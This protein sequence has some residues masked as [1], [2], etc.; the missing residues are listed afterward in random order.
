MK[1]Y[2]IKKK[3]G[4]LKPPNKKQKTLHHYLSRTQYSSVAEAFEGD[5]GEHTGTAAGDT[6]S[7]TEEQFL[8]TE[9]AGDIAGSGTKPGPSFRSFDN[10]LARYNESLARG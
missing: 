10:I 1:R 5:I 8:V 2:H 3:A 4:L 9:N 7:D 6:E